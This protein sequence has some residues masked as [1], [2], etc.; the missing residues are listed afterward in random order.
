MEIV[1]E[2]NH[3]LVAV[4]PAGISTQRHGE[5]EG[6]EDQVKAATGIVFLVPIHRLD[7]VVSGLVL[8][9]KSKKA[10]SRLQAQ[11]REKKIGRKYLAQVE[12]EMSGSGKLEHYLL[13][14]SH[15]AHVVDEN[16][17]GGKRASLEYQVTERGVEITLETGRYH[18][19]RAQLAAIGHPI[20]GDGKYGAKQNHETIA[21]S[22]VEIS[23]IHVTENKDLLIKV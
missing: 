23:F 1:F 4:K 5:R 19:I 20:V 2:D 7:T 21:L 17:E 16:T 11:M 22:C 3:H 14:K 6:F 12:G 15:M 18:Q 13:K 9:A 8:F 10:L